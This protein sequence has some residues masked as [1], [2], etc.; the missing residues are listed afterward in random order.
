M[1]NI[2]IARTCTIRIA[3]VLSAQQRSVGGIKFELAKLRKIQSFV[4]VP[5]PYSELRTHL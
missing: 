3:H 2:Y 5:L 4:M 1:Y